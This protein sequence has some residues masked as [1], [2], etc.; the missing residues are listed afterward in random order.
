VKGLF[1]PFHQ[2]AS[3]RSGH[4]KGTGLGLAISQRIVEAMGG[5]IRVS[6]TPGAGTQF[7]FALVFDLGERLET[8]PLPDSGFAPIEAEPLALRGTVLVVEDDPVNRLIAS[9]MLRS[10]G[11]GVLEASDGSEA[12]RLLVDTSVDLVLMDCEMPVMDGYTAT[13]RIREIENQRGL[14]RLPIIASTAN[15]SEQDKA[16]TRLV[17]MD[18]HIA[19]PYTRV[20]LR[21]TLLAFLS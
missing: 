15:A 21:Q 1:R 17:G 6:S 9:E 4:R 19:K 8:Q 13:Q 20:E 3:A 2:A 12:L 18:A 5:S 14:R 11:V 16:K 7:G 10:L